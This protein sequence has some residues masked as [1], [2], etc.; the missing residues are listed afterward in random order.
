MV[1][2]APRLVAAAAV[3]L[4]LSAY[5]CTDHGPDEDVPGRTVVI[6]I[7]EPGHLIPSNTVDVSGKQVLSALFQPLVTFDARSNP[8]PAAAQSVKAD[9][10]A[11]TWTVKLKPGLTFSNGEPVTADSYLDAWNY[12]AYGPNHQSAT[13]YYDRIDGYA[14]LQVRDPDG[15]SGPQQA[16]E[17]QTKTLRGLKKVSDTSFTVTLSAPFAGFAT[18]LNDVAFYPLPKAAFSAPGVIAGA[19]ENAVV[20]N[21]PFK[22]KGGWERGSRILME[23]APGFPGPAPKVDGLLWQIYDDAADEY[24]D[25]V[26]GVLDVQTRIPLELVDQA[27]EDLGG[28]LQKSPNSTFTFLGFPIFQPDFA[29]PEVRRALSLA[30]NRQAMVDEVFHGT[31]TAATA[32][33][34]PVVPGYR[35]DSCAEYC[36]YDPTRAKEMYR[37]AGG[38][39]AITV[40]YSRDSGPRSW[41]DVLCRQITASLGI[42]CTGAGEDDLAALLGRVE[43]RQPVGLI[44]LSWT[45][46]YPLLE[47]Y[48]SPLYATN[49]SSNLYGYSN[50]AFDSLLGEGSKAPKQAEAVKKWQEA[51]DLLAQDMPVIP[52][53]FGQNLFGHSERVRNVSID[54]AQ[55]IDVLSVELVG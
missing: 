42:K 36:R 18:L 19:F 14:D 55:R 23:K 4:V 26:D 6:G 46:D 30:I 44:R 5:G 12:G 7:S 32:F 15:D 41:V 2:K 29:E 34:S 33:V 37:A 51:E 54:S 38:P 43:K 28:R 39:A 31:E 22:M 48:L 25:L 50:P 35:A 11:R 24:A 47:S 9:P 20:G 17:P 10:T 1:R 49:G 21:G 40:S 3:A 52:L 16:A 8:V 53:R 13:S 45:M 27:T